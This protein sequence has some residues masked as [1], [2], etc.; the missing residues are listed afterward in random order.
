MNNKTFKEGNKI[1][2]NAITYIKSFFE[3]EEEKK[4]I[5]N[6]FTNISGK[7]GQYFVPE[8]LFQKRT[9]R[10]NRALIPFSHVKNFNI[11]YEQLN[12]FE[13]GVAVE[14]VNNDFFE[15]LSLPINKQNDVF[16]K[17]KDKLGTDDNV[18]AIIDIRSTG[19]S[20]SNVQREALNKL[21]KY[22]NDN[23]LK[24]KD[25]LIRRKKDCKYSGVGNEKWEG[26]VY[27]SIKG[28]Q[29]DAI[30]SHEEYKIPSK[31][32]QLF[33]PSVEY[34]GEHVSLDITLTLLFF[35]LFSINKNKRDE[36]WS[37]LKNDF[38][39]YFSNRIYLRKSLKDYV[40]NHISINIEKDM[41]IDP[42]QMEPIH[43]EDFAI[44]SRE[45]DALDITHQISVDQGVYEWDSNLHVLLT[46]A[47]P[48]NLFWSKYLSNMMQQHYSL[49]EYIKLQLEVAKKWR[50]YGLDEL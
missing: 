29:Q 38:L 37:T 36:K 46:P 18:S 5:S 6:K 4:L 33:N 32:V 50:E 17:L 25:V 9:P 30:D 3:T 22:L 39:N 7:T 35:T 15:E 41:L 47:S 28:G 1:K 2:N 43:I 16:K 8:T 11:T 31:D 24:M 45:S 21:K 26:F 42:I 40:E 14:F 34:A 20:S 13:N 44:K 10:K 49:N 12:S 19:D 23:N 48:T 27:Y